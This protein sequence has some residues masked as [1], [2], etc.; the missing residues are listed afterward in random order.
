MEPTRAQAV[1]AMLADGIHPITGERFPPDSPYQHPDI[2]RALYYGLRSVESIVR[3]KVEAAPS[4]QPMKPVAGQREPDAEAPSAPPPSASKASTPAKRNVGKPW[5]ADEEREL[6]A[7]FDA[8]AAV[9][10]LA[11]HHAR[12]VA[13]IEARLEKLG[14]LS[15][16]QRTTVSR[17]PSVTS[18][19]A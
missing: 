14:R 18:R 15:P 3:T 2:V 16:D 4:P 7:R 10:D 1:L 8:G 13:G 6:L 9:G 11:K 19:R 17:Y 5:S 12:S